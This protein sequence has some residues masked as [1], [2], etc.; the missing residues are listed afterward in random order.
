M[1][2]FEFDGLPSWSL[3]ASEAGESTKCPW[4]GVVEHAIN[5]NVTT[6]GHIV[7]FPV[8]LASWDQ[9][10]R[11]SNSMID[12]YDLMVKKGTVNSLTSADLNVKWTYFFPK[13]LDWNHSMKSS[14]ASPIPDVPVWRS[15][16]QKIFWAY[17]KTKPSK[18]TCPMLEHSLTPTNHNRP[19]SKLQCS[20]LSL[21]LTR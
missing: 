7:L 3:D 2:I 19:S 10:G 17:P 16:F 18:N 11:R 8:S 15:L 13:S 1:S 4:V 20:N 12:I 21:R 6:H 5:P 14:M 9:D